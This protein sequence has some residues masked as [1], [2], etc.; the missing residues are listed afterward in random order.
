MFAQIVSL[1]VL[2]LANSAPNPEQVVLGNDTKKQVS[3]TPLQEAILNGDLSKVDTMSREPKLLNQ[4]DSEGTPTLFYAIPYPS[5]FFTLLDRGVDINLRDRAGNTVAHRLAQG[6]PHR[7]NAWTF[8][9]LLKL[10]KR[11]LKLDVGNHRSE[12]PLMVAAGTGQPEIVSFLIHEKANVNNRDVDGKTA[13]MYAAA[14]LVPM[15]DHSEERMPCYQNIVI[16]IGRG[17]DERAK[18][19]N[20]KTALDIARSYRTQETFLRAVTEGRYWA[21][22]ARGL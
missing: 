21:T 22:G 9:F 10:H 3:R 2:L 8:D 15:D 11:G 6:I 20:G 12:T 13:L 4:V 18:N 17:A 1:G 5:S 19:R 16:L 14:G 7:S